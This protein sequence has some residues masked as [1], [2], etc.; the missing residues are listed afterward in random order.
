MIL[1]YCPWALK[2]PSLLRSLHCRLGSEPHP[3]LDCSGPAQG[4]PKLGIP[5]YYFRNWYFRKWDF[6]QRHFST[7]RRESRSAMD[8]LIMVIMLIR[9]CLERNNCFVCCFPVLL[10]FSFFCSSINSMHCKEINWLSKIIG[11]SE[12]RN[13]LMPL[14][15][16]KQIRNLRLSQGAGIS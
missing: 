6:R 10:L 2:S 5:P 15:C 16:P 11:N 14:E 7:D 8:V 3:A 1:W 4:C 12:I 13:A 9:G